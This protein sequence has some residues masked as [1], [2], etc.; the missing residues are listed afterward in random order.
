MFWIFFGYVWKLLDIVGNVLDI[1]RYSLDI[2]G[3]PVLPKGCAKAQV[4]QLPLGPASTK[5]WPT[6]NGKFQLTRCTLD[7][8][9]SAVVNM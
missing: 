9:V 2:L 1:V 5:R 7:W 6:A 3:S 4:V 8:R